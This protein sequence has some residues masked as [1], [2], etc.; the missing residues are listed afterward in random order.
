ME[1]LCIRLTH[2][3]ECFQTQNIE[4]HAQHR[5]GN[6]ILGDYLKCVYLNSRTLWSIGIQIYKGNK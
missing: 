4:A 2:F 3:H 1:F 5:A 6:Y